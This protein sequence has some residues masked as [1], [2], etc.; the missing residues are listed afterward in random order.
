MVQAKAK[1][2]Y[3]VE[4]GWASLEVTMPVSI[5]KQQ[6]TPLQFLYQFLQSL[7]LKLSRQ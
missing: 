4:S 5:E 7:G 3:D 6:A 1:D 2:I